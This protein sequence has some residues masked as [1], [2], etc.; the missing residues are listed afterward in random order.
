MFWEKTIGVKTLNVLNSETAEM[1]KL[2]NN[3]WIDLNIALANDLARLSDKLPYNIDILE[4]VKAANT[5]KKGMHHVNILSPSVGVGGYC[6]TKDP[7]FLYS[8]GKKHKIKLNTIKAGR[9]SNEI[10]PSYSSKIIIDFLKKII[11][12]T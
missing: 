1:V 9:D 7:W 3:A 6:L 2:A 10:M 8:L 11:L 4:V 5:L 12:K